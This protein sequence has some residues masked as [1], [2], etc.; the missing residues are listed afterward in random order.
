MLRQKSLSFLM[1][2]FLSPLK[3]FM[4]LLD[5]M[6]KL[7]KEGHNVVLRSQHEKFKPETNIYVVDTL[8]KYSFLFTDMK[9]SHVKLHI[10]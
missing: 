3:F 9:C 1:T 7:E 10:R 6:Q 4:L 2:F 8:G 5:V